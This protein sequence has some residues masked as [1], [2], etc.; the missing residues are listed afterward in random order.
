MQQGEFKK[1]IKKWTRRILSWVYLSRALTPFII[2]VI[3]GCL[4]VIVVLE[5]L[6]IM[7]WVKYVPQWII[8]ITACFG[9]LTWKK[10]LSYERN[11]GV[12][13]DFH[14]AVHEFTLKI[15]SKIQILEILKISIQSYEETF[16]IDPHRQEKFTCGLEEF[17]KTSGKSYSIQLKDGLDDLPIMHI[18][19]L[20]TKIRALNMKDSISAVNCYNQLAWLYDTIQKT[21]SKLSMTS[22][23]WKNPEVKEAMN[24][25]NK[26]D[27]EQLR[28]SLH[29]AERFMLV[30]ARKNYK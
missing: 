24:Q 23:Y 19:I 2:G 6:S 29:A 25:L 5:Y 12:V 4:A 10:K 21:A 20:S 27:I 11:M 1:C 30:F 14:G 26:L 22:L 9:L 13:D 18:Y 28:N 15:G 3:L 8:A 17:I 7:H 16:K